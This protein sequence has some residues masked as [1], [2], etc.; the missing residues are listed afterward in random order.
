[1]ELDEHLFQVAYRM[2]GSRAEA[3]DAVQEAWLRYTAARPDARDQRAWLTTVVGRI[4]LDVLRSARVRRE[5]YVGSWLPEPVVDRL[6]DSGPEDTVVRDE[7]VSYALL[8]V[9][10][11]LTPPQRVAFVLHDAFAVPFEDIATAL[12]TST[13]NARQLAARARKVVRDAQVPARTA[14]PGEQRRVL[15]AFLD[16]AR[17]GD[18]AGLARVLAPDVTL[19]GDGGG[20]APAIRHPMAGVDKVGRYLAGAFGSTR[21][22]PVFEPVLVNGDPGFLVTSG[23]IRMVMAPTVHN[24]QI[25]ALYHILNPEKLRHVP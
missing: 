17:H 11:R 13:D 21:Y 24:G 20:M 4:C 6:A 18:L 19:V 22:A 2:L 25:V 12:S 23:G 1:M 14:D 9:L 7:Q 3:Q 5:S 8:V 16:A 15:T 10:D